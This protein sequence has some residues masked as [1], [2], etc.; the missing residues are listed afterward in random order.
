MKNVHV[1]YDQSK[2]LLIENLNLKM[3]NCFLFSQSL[4]FV[5]TVVTNIFSVAKQAG[6]TAKAIFNTLQAY[7]EVKYF[8]LFNNKTFY[9]FQTIP[10]TQQ[11]QQTL[12]NTAN[13]S[14][15]DFFEHVDENETRNSILSNDPMKILIEMGFV[16]CTKNQRLLSENNNDLNKV[17]E[18]LTNSGNEDAN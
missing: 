6:S 3:N 18:L 15:D 5:D 1:H 7:D 9:V 10:S 17:I 4:D 12:I 14:V 2:L 11:K 16:N 13:S 8:I